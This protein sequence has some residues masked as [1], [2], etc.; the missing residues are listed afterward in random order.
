MKKENIITFKQIYNG[1]RKDFKKEWTYQVT[2]ILDT[3]DYKY[4]IMCLDGGKYP[5]IWKD[6]KFDTFDEAMNFLLKHPHY[7]EGGVHE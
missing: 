7:Y 3:N 4:K 2:P 5:S 1:K 6:W